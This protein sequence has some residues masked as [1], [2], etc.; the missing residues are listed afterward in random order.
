MAPVGVIGA[1]A[2]VSV[3]GEDLPKTMEDKVTS[4]FSAYARSIAAQNGYNPDI[5]AA[6]MD[7]N[8]D[9]VIDGQIIHKSGSVLS[10]S[11]QEAIRKIGRD[12]RPILASGIEED[13]GRL[14]KKIAPNAV[15]HEMS[16]TGAE[17]LA[18]WINAIAPLLILGGL[19]SFYIEFKTPGFGL[20]GIIGIACFTI[21]FIGMFAAGLSGYEP[22]TVF[23]IGVALVAVE[24]FILPGHIVPGLA[25]VILMIGSIIYAGIDKF[26]DDPI[27]PSPDK[28]I[29]PLMDL[30]IGVVGSLIVISLIARYLPKTSVYDVLVLTGPKTSAPPIDGTI[31]EIRE[32]DEGVAETNLR[33]A[34]KARFGTKLVDVVTQGE[35]IRA[36]QPVKV[37]L[38]EGVR[39][40]VQE[41]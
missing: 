16:P 40:V 4:G 25:G 39:V 19:V 33:P 35:M 8:R 31:A 3:T 30:G 27:I 28:L 38:R 32:G 10:F 17:T 41:V 6:F 15:V 36:G 29:P 2:V 7:K 37:V 11:S 1:S 12:Q 21:F 20:P 13:L 26:P 5:A 9:V 14:I 34:G 18:F 24:L 22:L 23:M